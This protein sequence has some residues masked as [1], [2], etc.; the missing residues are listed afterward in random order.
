MIRSSCKA[1]AQESVALWACGKGAFGDAHQ[2]KTRMQA[3][4]GRIGPVI[5]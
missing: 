2:V 4:A 5:S 1:F 3:E